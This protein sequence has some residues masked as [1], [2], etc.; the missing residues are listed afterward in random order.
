MV[1]LTLVACAAALAGL[2]PAAP[3]RADESRGELLY[4]THCITCHTA[5]MH[6]R[7]QRAATDWDSLRA[8]VRR[9][10]AVELLRWS[11]QDIAHVA[12]Y[13]NRRYYHFATPSV[14][15]GAG[16]PAQDAAPTALAVRRPGDAPGRER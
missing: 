16:P 6:W 13:L 1:R 12:H 5:Q 11:E 9:W 3:A 10:Q 8:N 7:E 2:L 14:P 4:R 15:V